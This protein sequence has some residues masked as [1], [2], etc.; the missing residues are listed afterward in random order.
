MSRGCPCIGSKA[1]GIPELLNNTFIFSIGNIK[2]LAN[3][4]VSLDTEKMI[5]QAK[6]NFEF[7]KGYAKEIIEKRRKEFFQ[8]FAESVKNS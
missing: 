7:S 8:E 2:E 6:R 5:K 3:I 1:G 4:L